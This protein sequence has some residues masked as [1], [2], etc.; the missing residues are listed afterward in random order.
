MKVVADELVGGRRGVREVASQLGTLH[1][2]RCVIAEPAHL[3]VACNSTQKQA[4]LRA[5]ARAVMVV[6]PGEGRECFSLVSKHRAVMV[7]E[8][9]RS[10]LRG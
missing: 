9:Q 5:L 6:K 7:V 8:R 3:R 10:L 1:M 4:P 2:D